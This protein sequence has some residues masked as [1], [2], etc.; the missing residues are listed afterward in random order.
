M[1]CSPDLD[2]HI[3]GSQQRSLFLAR[4]IFQIGADRCHPL[5]DV[6][7]VLLRLLP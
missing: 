3:E 7:N 2:P 4:Q 5:L 6:I 1:V